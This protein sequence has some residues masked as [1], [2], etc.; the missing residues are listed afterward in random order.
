[1][2]S[3][4]EALIQYYWYPQ[5]KKKRNQACTEK[6]PHARQGENQP[7]Q[8]LELGL[9]A[10]RTMRNK[11]LTFE[12]HSLWYFVIAALTNR[13]SKKI[14]I[15]NALQNTGCQILHTE[16]LSYPQMQMFSREIP[17]WSQ[18]SILELTQS[19]LSLREDTMS[20]S[21][22]FFR[23]LAQCLACYRS[24]VIVRV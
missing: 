20:Y 10:P 3:Y 22:L 5:K 11:I 24:L 15:L 23:E 12:I 13:E 6:R 8:Y 2:R 14:G 18:L 17:I 21:P 16:K 7:C 4:G 9:V 1:M 19:H